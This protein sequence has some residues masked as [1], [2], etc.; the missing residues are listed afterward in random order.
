MCVCFSGVGEPSQVSL[1]NSKGKT[2]LQ[3]QSHSSSSL[4]HEESSDW[5]EALERDKIEGK[6]WKMQTHRRTL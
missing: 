1:L 2:D 3:A 4:Y 5:E 6:Q